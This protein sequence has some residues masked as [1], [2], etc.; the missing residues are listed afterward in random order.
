MNKSPKTN[1]QKF[2]SIVG[3]M[4]FLLFVAICPVSKAEIFLDRNQPYDKLSSRIVTPHIKWANPYY[5]GKIKALVIAPMLGQ[6]ETIE[7]AQRLSLNYTPLMTFDYDKMYTN[8]PEFGSHQPANKTIDMIVSEKLKKGYDVIVIGKVS[9]KILPD[10]VRTWIRSEVSKGTGMIYVCPH[11][12]EEIQELFDERKIADK[13]GFVTAGVPLNVLS[14]TKDMDINNL[15]NLSLFGKGRVVKIDYGEKRFRNFHSLTPLNVYKDCPLNYE[16]YHSLLAKSVLW[17]SN[18][19]PDIYIKEMRA[20]DNLLLIKILSRGNKSRHAHIELVVRNKD[21]YIEI[22]KESPVRLNKGIREISF[23][24][25]PLDAGL[26]FLDIWVKEQGKVMNWGSTSMTVAE[27]Y[28][29]KKLALDKESYKLGDVVQGKVIFNQAPDKNLRLRIQLLDNF[30]RVMDEKILGIEGGKTDFSFKIKQALSVL[31]KVKANLLSEKQQVICDIIKEFPVAQK[32]LDDYFFSMWVG[33]CDNYLG[34]L[35]LKLFYE[36]GVDFDFCRHSAPDRSVRTNL[37]PIPHM[38]GF[39]SG[40]SYCTNIKSGIVRKPCFTDPEFRGKIKKRWQRKVE[41]YK[42]YGSYYCLSINGGLSTTRCVPLEFCFSP[43]C[44]EY[45]RGYL[46]KEYKDLD[47][48]NHEWETSY[49]SWDEIHPMTFEEAKTHGNFAPWADHRMAMERVFTEI[50]LFAKNT[51]LEIDPEA[52]VGIDEPNETSSCNGYSWWELMNVLDYCNPYFGKWHWRDDQRE[53]FRAFAKEGNAPTGIWFGTYWRGENFNRFIP[54]QSLFNGMKGIYWWQGVY[55]NGIGALGYDFA[56]MPFF[57]QALEEIN[58]IKGGVGKLL[59]NSIRENDKIAIHYSPS[60]VHA[61][62][63]LSNSKVPPAKLPEELINDFTAQPDTPTQFGT[64][65]PLYHSQQSFITVLED[66]GLQYNFVANE[67]IE[68]GELEKSNYKVLILPYAQA[69]SSDET[70]EIKRFVQR[71]GMVI[72]DFPPGIMDKH[73]KKLNSSSLEEIFGN[74]GMGLKVGKYGSGKAVYL[75]NF[76]KNYV[77]LRVE[78]KEKEKRER[79]KQVIKMAGI[80]PRLKIITSAGEDLGATEV[81][82]FKSGDVEYACLLRDYLIKD[83]SPK[84]VTVK[85]PYKAHIYDAREGRYYGF[86]QEIKTKIFPARAKIFALSPYKINGIS[87]GLDKSEYSQGDILFYKLAVKT[88]VNDCSRHVFRLELI[89]PAGKTVKYYC[90][91]L[92]VENGTYSGVLHLSLN[93]QQGKWLLKAKEIISGK[94]AKQ[95]FVV[96]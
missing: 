41:A 17:A 92:I 87:I 40:Y 83:L 69:L 37:I 76:L 43:T 84:K 59:I 96:K 56:P 36:A 66:I 4:T 65:Y 34:S 82:F 64:A 55:K 63:I 25:P 74:F 32:K 14:R 81:V 39:F 51:I 52:V 30:D 90:A 10:K 48:L 42:K 70:K 77:S 23:N 94:T 62:T 78:G 16:Y 58:E 50:N 2:S 31:L 15:I 47:T 46:K 28:T 9:W 12:C 29:I 54:W 26:H 73:C 75:H 35:V 19:E 33:P 13:E 6:R 71:G 68:T 67:Q 95:F 18:K 49:T 89:N 88:G 7:L 61:A 57:E 21:N 22:R 80:E 85:F 79:I 86:V 60:C 5:K 93:E 45:F 38:G 44:Q 27:K 3:I 1:S 11:D 91:N 24:L 53:L 8:R 20:T 72:A